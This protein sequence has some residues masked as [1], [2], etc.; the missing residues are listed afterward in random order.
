[1]GRGPKR[2][3]KWAVNEWCDDD[4]CNENCAIIATYAILN[5]F[6]TSFSLSQRLSTETKDR[7]M[8]NGPFYREHGKEWHRQVQFSFFHKVLFSLRLSR[9][10]NSITACALTLPLLSS[11]LFPCPPFSL[12]LSLSPFLSSPFAR[13]LATSFSAHT[14]ILREST[15]NDGDALHVIM[16]LK[17]C[18]TQSGFVQ[19][20]VMIFWRQ[21]LQNFEWSS[22]RRINW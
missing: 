22:I 8:A 15:P 5:A 21:T 12:R 2:E 20:A 4:E 14:T 10:S 13:S 3:E 1:M 9:F 11:R 7:K 19:C 6:G 18:E 17:Q 16:Y